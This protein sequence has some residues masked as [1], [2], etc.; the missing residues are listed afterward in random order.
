MHGSA[1]PIEPQRNIART[2]RIHSSPPASNG[3]GSGGE[4]PLVQL[5]HLDTLWFQVT[6][7]ICNLRCVHCFIS[8][9]PDN[10]SFEFLS[11]AEVEDWLRARGVGV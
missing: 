6:G 2:R 1:P 10:D 3:A 8:C 9:A 11:L 4:A 7:T 5:D